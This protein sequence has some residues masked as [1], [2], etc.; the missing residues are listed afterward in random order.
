MRQVSR[1]E[2]L[3]LTILHSSWK[4]SCSLYFVDRGIDKIPGVQVVLGGDPESIL[5]VLTAV[6]QN[7][8]MPVVVFNG[9][10][11]A[12]NLLAYAIRLKKSFF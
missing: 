1:Y 7:F 8:P 12:A 9:S 10:G 6:K 2:K 5:K 4:L 11:A 3:I